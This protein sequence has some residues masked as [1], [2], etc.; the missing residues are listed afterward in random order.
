MKLVS[1]IVPVYN[2]ENEL[3]KCVLS[4]INQTYVNIEIILVDDGSTDN[5]GA[6]C[7]QFADCYTNV[8]A[9]HKRNGG[10]SSARNMALTYVN[11][12]YL[13]FV[14]SDDYI[15]ND[16]IEIMMQKAD[17]ADLVI[18]NYKKVNLIG[19]REKQDPMNVDE[20]C[21]SK[22][23]FWQECYFQGLWIFCVVSWNK[24]Y[25]KSLFDN[26]KFPNHK[27][28]EDEFVIGR[29]ISLTKKIKVI[30]D[31]LYFYVQR[32]GSIMHQ[33]QIGN[34]DLAEALLRRS[35]MF[36]DNNKQSL[37]I[38]RQNLM[39]ISKKLILGFFENHTETEKKR[40]VYLRLKYFKK[41]REY[42]RKEFNWRLCIRAFLLHIPYIYY[43]AL[44][45]FH[46]LNT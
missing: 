1:V 32:Q 26:I 12:E 14:D 44:V 16:M 37:K 4:I 27:L 41:V 19:S 10:L 38:L 11:G 9:Y 13:V 45:L 40:F 42:S 36:S 34:L 15:A 7:D 18:C 3:K 25:R 35:D 20:S 2:V 17:G 33:K 31:T 43:I 39:I 29:I 24:L 8:K 30:T 21:W 46:R 6:I 23:K 22:Y 28:H 5:S